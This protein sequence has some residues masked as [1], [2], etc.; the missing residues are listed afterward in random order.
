MFQPYIG[1][2]VCGKREE[3]EVLFNPKLYNAIKILAIP[4][5]VK[6]Y[7]SEGKKKKKLPS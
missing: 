6:F 5:N 3:W 4:K 1:F 2:R 7:I